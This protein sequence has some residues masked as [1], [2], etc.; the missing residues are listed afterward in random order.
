MSNQQLKE[1]WSN[2]DNVRNASPEDIQSD[3]LAY[4]EHAEKAEAKV[5]ELTKL[6]MNA[7]ELLTWRFE[8]IPGGKETAKQEAVN[9][10]YKW[11]IENSNVPIER[12]DS[13]E[14]DPRD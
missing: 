10:I 4:I 12:V 3:V 6:L 1:F 9:L 5:S 13:N 7:S 11:V 2:I 14:L 8:E